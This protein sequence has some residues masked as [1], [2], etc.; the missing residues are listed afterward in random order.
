MV[1]FTGLGLAAL[2]HF[3]D[4]KSLPEDSGFGV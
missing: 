4:D 2:F 1:Y 3:G